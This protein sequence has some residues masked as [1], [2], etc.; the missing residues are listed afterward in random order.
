[1]TGITSIAFASFFLLFGLMWGIKDVQPPQPDG[2]DDLI[3]PE[4]AEENYRKAVRRQAI[5]GILRLM[6]LGIGTLM[7]FINLI[8]G[9]GTLNDSEGFLIFFGV[10]GIITLAVQRSE[11]N[12]RLATLVI[13]IP[14][15]LYILPNY[16]NYR[17]S[18]GAHNW[19]VMAAL[20]ANYLFWLVIG[21]R[22]PP[23]S[24][25]DIHVW[26]MDE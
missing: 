26:G 13:S 19:G 6:L 23:G 21:R 25:E 20:L 4:E 2:D 15:W 18:D 12:R 1:M 17:D 9:F 11:K 10:Y 24:S 5:F 7:L 3:D 16:G 8:A 22:Y 14:L